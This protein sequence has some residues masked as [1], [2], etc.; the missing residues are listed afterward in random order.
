MA[1]GLDTLVAFC[2][3]AGLRPTER[4]ELIYEW[5]SY[6]LREVKLLRP[7]ARVAMD[8]L[9]TKLSN[10]QLSRVK[11]AMVRAQLEHD[12]SR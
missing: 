8:A 10:A 3:L 7:A 11:R 12:R 1:I 2:N 4:D 9:E 5:I 6:R